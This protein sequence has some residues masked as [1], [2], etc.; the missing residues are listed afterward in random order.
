[1][2]IILQFTFL[3]DRWMCHEQY[4]FWRRIR[5]L[6][7]KQLAVWGCIH[8]IL[9]FHTVRVTSSM[10]MISH[11]HCAY[12]PCHTYTAHLVLNMMT[13]KGPDDTGVS[14]WPLHLTITAWQHKHM[15]VHFF[16]GNKNRCSVSKQIMDTLWHGRARM[17][18][19]G[20]TSFDTYRLQQWGNKA[21]F[22]QGCHYCALV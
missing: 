3:F 22:G 21:V 2:H 1:M 18:E 17:V 12:R 13:P 6:C 5:T 9:T 4:T 19:F 11:S 16:A 20:S 15:L 8:D 14:H 10:L 7:G